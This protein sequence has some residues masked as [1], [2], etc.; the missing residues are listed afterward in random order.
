[1]IRITTKNSVYDVRF[2]DEKFMVQKVKELNPKSKHYRE[3]ESFS[4]Y[5]ITLEY[6]NGGAWFDYV[7]TSP[8]EKIEEVS[9]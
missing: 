8:I 3:G 9:E 6:G 5:K 4:C 2:G 7:R 1:M